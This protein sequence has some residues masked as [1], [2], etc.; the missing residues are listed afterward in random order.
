MLMIRTGSTNHLL[1]CRDLFHQF[2]VDMYAKVE[3]ERLLYIRQN[4]KKLRA[5]KF[6]HLQ[7]ATVNDGNAH[8]VGQLVI[9]PSTF[10]GGPRYMHERTQ[11]AMTYVRTYGR[12][13]LFITFTCNPAWEEIAGLLFP[14]QPEDQ[15]RPGQES[16]IPGQQP[17]HRHDLV[18]R[19]FR[20][21]LQKMM[22]LITKHSIF[23]PTLCHMYTIEWQKRGLPHAHILIWLKDKIR[24]NQ[25]DSVISAE[26]P[27][28]EEDPEL[29]EVIKKQMVH[30]PCGAQNPKAPCMVDGKCSKGFPKPFLAETE[31]GNDGYPSYRRRK[32]GQGGHEATV[33]NRKIDNRW[34]V[35]YSPLLSKIFKAHVNVEFCNSIKSIKYVCKYV[36]KGSDMA[37]FGI[38]EWNKNDEIKCYQ[39]ARYISSNEAVWRLFN[40]RLHERYP[41][42]VQLAVHLE[43]GQRVY[44]DPNNPERLQQQLENP[45][46]TTLTAFFEL[47]QTDTFAATLLYP[48]VPQYFTWLQSNKWKRRAMGREVEGQPGVKKDSALGRVYTVHPNN[49]E[50]YFL[51]LLLHKVR[52]PKSFQDLKTVDGH[53]CDTFRQACQLHGLLEDDQHW[54]ATLTEAAV[55]SSAFQLRNLFGIMLQSCDLSSPRQL[56]DNH[57]ED[58]CEDI[59]HR[60]QRENPGI[61]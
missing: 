2:V 53:V 57:K 51:R 60:V 40:F 31:T 56:F 1:K 49:F 52:G 22:A 33:K 45:R 6:V 28:P 25:I 32:P 61:L 47:C 15:L 55:S 11:D 34:T 12:P 16:P 26:L 54:E 5:E 30:G 9:L 29:F 10:T 24:P 46:H 13:D 20:Q 23:G 41:A 43:N 44:F 27:N 8:N 21:K 39:M 48:E 3:G 59:L 19:V 38:Q 58:F 50:C 18:A 7:D 36:N 14:G 35:P 42:V 4:Q 37:M 17:R